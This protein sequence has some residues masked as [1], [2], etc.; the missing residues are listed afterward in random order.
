MISVK[1]FGFKGVTRKIFR[2]KELARAASTVSTLRTL[3]SP[4]WGS[5]LK[6]VQNPRLAPWAL[7][8]RRFA[9]RNASA[10]C[11]SFRT[12]DTGSF[13]ELLAP[14]IVFIAPGGHGENPLTRRV[15]YLEC[16]VPSL[17]SGFRRA[18]QTP[19]KRLNFDSFGS[20]RSPHIAQD[21]RDDR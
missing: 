17:R 12:C 14:V 13:G 9:A 6:A 21:D 4:L 8:L 2:N 15:R 19:R 3:L 7:F 10:H 5:A 16:R 20:L 11:F 1:I 18:A